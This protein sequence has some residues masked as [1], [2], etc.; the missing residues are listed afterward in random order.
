M[1][2]SN[3]GDF[4]IEDEE[5]DEEGMGEEISGDVEGE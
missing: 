1:M 2:C 5:I 3:P 4:K